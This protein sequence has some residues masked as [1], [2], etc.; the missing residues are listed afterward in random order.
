MS[1][2]EVLNVYDASGQYNLCSF[3]RGNT[4][5]ME[6][7]FQIH[8]GWQLEAFLNNIAVFSMDAMQVCVSA[9]LSFFNAAG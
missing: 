4:N 3:R 5:A 7:V 1:T 8:L 2:G 6:Q 9:T